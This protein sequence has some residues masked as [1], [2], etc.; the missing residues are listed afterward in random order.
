MSV[1]NRIELNDCDANTGWTGDDSATPI[2]VA[3]LFYQGT[4][5]LSTQLSNADEHMYT[6]EDSLNTG[7]FSIDMSDSTLYLIVKDNQQDEQANGGMKVVVGDGTNR[8]GIEVAGYDNVGVP[9]AQLFYGLRADISNRSAF[10]LHTFAGAAGSLTD[11]AISEVG[12]GSLHL[13]KAQG[14]VDNVFM[15]Y[16][17]YIANGSPALTINGGSSGTPETWA[18]VAGDDL[19]NG[20]GLVG[21]PFASQFVIGCPFEV[22]EDTVSTDSYFAMTDDQL[23][24]LGDV[25]GAG[26]FFWSLLSGTGTQSMVLTR[27]TLISVAG[28]NG[29]PCDLLWNDSNFNILQLDS[30]TIIDAGAINFSP[31]SAGNRFVDATT[32]INCGQIDFSSMDADGCTI[33]GT[34]NANG[35]VRWDE[36][37]S[38]VA[39]QDNMTFVRNGTHNAIEIAPTGAG[40]FT[41]NISGYEFDGFAS[42]DDGDAVEAEKVFYINPSTLS[43]DININLTDCAAVNIGGGADT[44]TDGFSYRVVGSYAGTVTITQTV[45]LQVTVADADT[46]DT[47]E[48]CLVSIRNASTNALISQGRTDASGVYTDGSYNYTGNL[49]V[50]IETRRSSPGDIRYLPKRDGAT[51]TANGLS[52]TV[53]LTEDTNAG[54]IELNRFD[55][56][57]QGQLTRDTS[58]AGITV[59]LKLPGGTGRK[60]VVAAGYWDATAN[61]TVSAMTYDGNAM[62]LETSNF[63]QEGA[64]F[65]E[66]FLYRYDIPDADTGTKDVVLTLSAACPFRFLAFAVLTRAG[67]GAAE[68]NGSSVGQAVTSNPS[69][70]LNNTTQPAI[71]L[72][73][74]VTDDT[75][76][77]SATGVGSIRRDDQSVDGLKKVTFIRADRTATGS[78][79]L[80]ADYGA[81]SKAYVSVGATFAD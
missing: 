17:A 51:I 74:A 9:L 61:L 52:A 12:Y 19:T 80:G 45:T 47:I 18:D 46:G 35:A 58:A 24:L 63:V 22:G 56:A 76:A 13:A 11:T 20:W 66:A 44:G 65:H 54:I 29:S 38:D 32:F 26:N 50:N 78:H 23:Y 2:N 25:F 33:N 16:F 7:T 62:T 27:A 37:T 42:Q 36:N 55:V 14:A 1:D 28:A 72:M 48:D 71:D 8:V 3:G 21:N 69:I 49:A 30:C 59:K 40:P 6:T 57:K 60:L 67:S 77:P 31:Q 70:T 10:T 79:S 68:D 39:N 75:D 4:N 73:W 5:A 81:N 64:A 15:D 43:A 34:T 41:Y 53:Q